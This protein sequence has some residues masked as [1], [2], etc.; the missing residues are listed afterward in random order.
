MNHA[1]QM[2][3]VAGLALGLL[4]HAATAQQPPR[5]PPAGTP[6]PAQPSAPGQPAGSNT[7]GAL[8][9][10]EYNLVFTAG[11]GYSDNVNRV[12]DIANPL[13]SARQE[14]STIGLVGLEFTA[15][16]PNGRLQL[17][18]SVDLQFL[19]YFDTTQGE[20]ND[21]SGS[22]FVNGRYEFLP[23]RLFWTLDNTFT[24]VRE[25]FRLPSS[26]QNRQNYN[27]LLTGPNIVF[28]LGSAFDL[29]TELRYGR[30]D[31]EQ[32]SNVDSQSYSGSM[33]LTR[34]L[35]AR[36][37]LSLTAQSESTDVAPVPA[38]LIATGDL[39][40]SDRDFERREVYLRWLA[41]TAR[42]NISIDAGVSEVEGEV[43]GDSGPL[44]RIQLSRELTPSLRLGLGAGRQFATTGEFQREFRL[45]E[46]L[47]VADDLILP[48]AEP[49]EQTSY[50]LDLAYQ[51]PRTTFA[52]GVTRSEED[53]E[54]VSAVNRRTMSYQASVSRRLTPRADIRIF[55]GRDEDELETR[56]YDVTDTSYGLGLRWRLTRSIAFSFNATQRERSSSNVSTV[57][58]GNDYD[59]LY[60]NF[61][62]R[63]SPWSP[64]LA[65]EG[66]GAEALT[67]GGQ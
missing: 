34:R 23:D 45:N 2:S 58:F 30:R 7:L 41:Q 51:R 15:D 27:Q 43:N 32:G 64:D 29:T 52:L 42:T 57:A 63:Y 53:Y 59:E 44:V 62:I 33:A 20:D 60:A 39:L 46:T 48:A 24:Q 11:G 19:H 3:A 55:A 31:Y 49:F 40:Q 9:G 50:S 28:R 65:L 1:S 37:S 16:K 18:S 21:L 6:R 22:A 66:D 4:A 8:A 12:S 26:P 54:F 13:V 47:D 36:S 5:T 14:S 38:S 17:Q 61:L 25:N 10:G 67:G 35:S 56:D